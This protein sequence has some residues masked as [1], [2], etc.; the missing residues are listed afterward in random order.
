[1][2]D[3]AQSS[4]GFATLGANLQERTDTARAPRSAGH[5]LNAAQPVLTPP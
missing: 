5:S 4:L 3:E 1:V 2:H